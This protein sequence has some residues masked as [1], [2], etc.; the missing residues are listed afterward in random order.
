MRFVPTPLDGAFVVE[1]ERHEDE[2]GF[3]ARTWAEEELAAHGLAAR[4][5]QCSI[6]RN[7]HAGTVRGMHFQTHPH[8][9]VKLVRCTA[10][11]VYDVIVDL[12][13]DSPTHARW[14][15]AELDA[16]RG[17]ALYIPK[18]LAH[19]FQTL[20]DG[21]EVLYMMGDPY[22]PGAATGV[23][24]DDPA[25]GIEWPLPVRTINERDR[26]WPDYA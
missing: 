13:R 4:I 5:V 15:A 7:T 2:R 18:G 20:A 9:E 3:F 8:W 21:A 19:G 16:E 17:N 26:T 25:F 6:S 24:Y 1:L 22:V 12:R 14:F 23:R 10:G 11:A